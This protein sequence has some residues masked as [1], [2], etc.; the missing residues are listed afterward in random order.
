M[1]IVEY[2]QGEQ[3]F[4]GVIGVDAA[5]VFVVGLASNP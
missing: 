1:G 4:P 2:K 3:A 5:A